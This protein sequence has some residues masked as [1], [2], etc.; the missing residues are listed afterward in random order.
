MR[1]AIGEIV[2]VVIGILIALQI[3]N[4]NDER[5]AKIET[6][7]IRQSN[8]EEIYHDLK[9]DVINLD[10]IIKQLQVQKEASTYF[11][12]ILESND[13]YISDSLKFFKNQFIVSNSL[14]IDKPENT[15]DNLNMSGQL[16]TLK[17]DTLTKKLFEYYN[18]YD[19][20]VKNFS[21]LPQQARLEFRK[22]DASCNTLNDIVKSDSNQVTTFPNPSYFPCFLAANGLHNSLIYILQSCYF[23][24]NWF[25]QLKTQA[26]SIIA[27][28][29]ENHLQDINFNKNI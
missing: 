8:L 11:L 18:F 27:Y 5:K 9:K 16:L 15:W 24:I 23:N 10:T 28:M 1:Y 29:E 21:E 14:T 22:L 2:L 6:E 17:E 13:K 25:T 3:N 12:E 20:R 4:W 26:Q 7:A 19:S